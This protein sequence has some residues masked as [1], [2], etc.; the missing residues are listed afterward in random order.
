MDTKKIQ[1]WEEDHMKAE[2][3]IEVMPRNAKDCSELSETR[4]RQE[5]ILP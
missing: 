2:A 3:E 4:R 1:S 5:S